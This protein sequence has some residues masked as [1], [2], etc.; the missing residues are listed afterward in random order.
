MDAYKRGRA[1]GKKKKKRNLRGRNKTVA[2]HGSCTFLRCCCFFI[3]LFLFF[4][5]S[6]SSSL[7]PIRLSRA[8]TRENK[9]SRENLAAVRRTVFVDPIYRVS[10]GRPGP[11]RF[12]HALRIERPL[13]AR[14]VSRS[15]H[16]FPPERGKKRALRDDTTRG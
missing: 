3:S 9:T 10:R 1:N 16:H 8:P 15:P 6:S 11:E 4:S 12:R 7:F 13:R 5:S 2:T 14:T